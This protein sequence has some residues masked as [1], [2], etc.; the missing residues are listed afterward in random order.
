MRLPWIGEFRPPWWGWLVLVAAVGAL[1]ALGT[2][3]LARAQ[4]K[5]E[6]IA[7]RSSLGK[8][9]TVDLARLPDADTAYGQ[10]ARVAGHY[11]GDQILLDNQV[12]Q[13]TVGYRVWTPLVLAD[14]RLVLVDR[15]WVAA[16]GGRD[17]LPQPEVPSGQRQVIGFWH[18]LP[19]PGLRL[20]APNACA[21]Q[22]W[23]RRLNYPSYDQVTCQYERP[24]VNGILLLGNDQPGGFPRD[25]TDVGLSPMRHIGYA[26]QWFAMAA[27]V[28]VLFV[29]VNRRRSRS[30]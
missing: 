16:R 7:Q 12:W 20:A 17:Q 22:G 10:A 30:Q 3:Q 28:V 21:K 29:L 26:V 15:G 25:W 18:R 27:A 23:P 11:A 1:C 24:V 2:W 13:G 4:T 5:R 8:I 19:K 9:P 6:I 14:G